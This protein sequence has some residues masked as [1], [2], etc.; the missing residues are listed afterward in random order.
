[1]RH[2][3][4][5][6]V[7]PLAF[8][9]LGSSLQILDLSANNITSLPD[10]VFDNFDVFRLVFDVLCRRAPIRTV[11]ISPKR[12]LVKKCTFGDVKSDGFLGRTDVLQRTFFMLFPAQL[13]SFGEI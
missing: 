9:G 13:L 3:S 7:S 4:L 10:N 12:L 8:E 2:C 6:Y 5:Q 11:K 1:M